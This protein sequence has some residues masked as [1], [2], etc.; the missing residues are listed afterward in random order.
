[1]KVLIVK[2]SSMGDVLHTLPAL[3]DAAKHIPGIQ[4]DWL[5]EESFAEIP[6]WHPQVRRVIPVAFRRMRR[7]PLRSIFS[8]EWR[9]F[10]KILRQEK[11][12]LIIDAQGLIKSAFI[13]LFAHGKRAGLDKGSAREKLAHIV[14]Q[15]KVTVN[16]KQHAV[17]RMR[18]LFAKVLG[19]DLNTVLDYGI[20]REQFTNSEL[21]PE[22][23]VFFFHGTTWVTKLWPVNYWR[24]LSDMVTQAGMKVCLTWGN[25]E[26]KKRAEII[27]NANANVIVLPKMSLKEVTAHI[28]SAAAIVSVDTGLGH[29]AAALGAPTISLY[30]PTDAML[31][32][33]MGNNQ[34]HLQAQFPACA[35][36]LQRVCTYQGMSEERPACFASMPPAFVFSH[37]KK[38]IA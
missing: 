17:V 14:Y 18:E 30:G 23:F 9:D 34:I 37:L 12:D 5:V 6:L 13:S 24:Q 26:E 31:T 15:K 29:V 7:T 11:Y 8:K 3:T 32:G 4:F 27:A 16:F 2:M 28:A 38:L 35:P 1:M 36:C 21:F 20:T 22:K 19:Y 25:E 10:L 33:T